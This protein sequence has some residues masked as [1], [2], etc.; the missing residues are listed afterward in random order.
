MFGDDYPKEY[1]SARDGEYDYTLLIVQKQRN[2][3][4]ESNTRYNRP[5]KSGY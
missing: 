2:T 3:R 4:L 1:F 5:R